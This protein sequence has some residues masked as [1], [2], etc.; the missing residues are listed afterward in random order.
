MKTYGTYTYLPGGSGVRAKWVIRA[1]PHVMILVKRIFPRANQAHTGAVTI[2]DTPDVAR[3]IEWLMQRYPLAPVDEVSARRLAA[4]ANVCRRRE[5]AVQQ[6]LDGLAIPSRD[7]WPEPTLTPRD[8]Q[9]QAAELVWATGRLLIADELGLGKTFEGALV[10][11]HPEALPALVVVPNNV[12]LQ[13]QREL[14]RFFPWMRTHILRSRKPYDIAAARGNGGE[15]PDVLITSYTRLAGWADML[16]GRIRTVIYDEMQELRHIG[17]QKGTA[18]AMIAHQATFRVGLTGTPVYNYGDEMHT[19]ASILDPEA[20]GT[21][22]EFLRE[23]CSGD[24]PYDPDA[25]PSRGVRVTDPAAL[26]TYLRDIGLVVRR[27]RKDVGRELPEVIQVEQLVETD[28]ETLA[29]LAGDVT[30]MARLLLDTTADHRKRWHTA[31][32]F[33]LRV[34]QA[35]GIA[36]APYVAEFVRLLLESERKVVLVGW[37]RAV[38]DIWLDKLRDFNPVLY[39]GTETSAQKDENARRFMFGD[40]RVLIMS[41][42]SGAGLDGLQ[43]VCNVIV[44]GELDW[45]PGIHRQC[46][47]RLHRDGQDN[48]VIAYYLVSDE[49]SDPPM[50]DVLGVKRQQSEPIV[51]PTAPVAELLTQPDVDRIR[52]LARYVLDRAEARAA[53]QEQ[54]EGAAAETVGSGEE[55][56]KVVYV[57]EAIPV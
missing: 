11:R 38:Y 34:R 36:K 48:Q 10:L 31:S 8:Y 18:A 43:Q 47:G 46:I 20:L 57:Q 12:L 22:A 29:K 28:A 5:T 17:T 33:D 21:R 3:D 15:F 41:L 26:G 14:V 27:T 40:S 45:S 53:E 44:F 16:A 51:D 6:I 32:E 24:R 30:E 50:A 23:W 35:T 56:R 13:W 42:R 52:A 9:L 55:E 39:T 7:D 54:Q 1:E 19:L 49:G 25:P 37:H 4:Q 2:A